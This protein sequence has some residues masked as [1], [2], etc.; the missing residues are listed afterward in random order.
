[1]PAPTL[2]QQ[3]TLA[4]KFAE[5]WQHETN[6]RREK[7]SFW[8]DFFAIFG[9]NRQKYAS[10]EFAVKDAKNNTQFV[11]VF[12]K[13]VFLAEHKSAKKDLGRAKEQAER[14]MLHC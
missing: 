4:T 9:M 10:F 14:Y 3:L 8:N 2:K 11:D 1:M 6:E 7:D 5:N 13:G 12:Y